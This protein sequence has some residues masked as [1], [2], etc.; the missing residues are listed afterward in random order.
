[1]PV[2]AAALQRAKQTMSLVKVEIANANGADMVHVGADEDSILAMEN[3]I[4]LSKAMGGEVPEIV[5]LDYKPSSMM[6]TMNAVKMA[7]NAANDDNSLIILEP[8][9]GQRVAMT[10]NPELVKAYQYRF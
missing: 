3:V 10:K 8:E 6:E 9:G 5:K 4:E 7:W 1:M 2:V